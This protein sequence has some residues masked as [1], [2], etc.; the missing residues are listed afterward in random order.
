MPY[1]TYITIDG[2]EEAFSSFD[3]YDS[4]F[5]QYDDYLTIAQD[6]IDESKEIFMDPEYH[7]TVEIV[8]YDSDR[9]NVLEKTIL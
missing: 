6:I 5:G 1:N 4:A 8:L 2:C 9:G 7:P 3:D